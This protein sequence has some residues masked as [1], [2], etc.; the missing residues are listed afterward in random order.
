MHLLVTQVLRILFRHVFVSYGA[1]I[2]RLVE[3]RE[4]IA[5]ELDESPTY[6][7]STALMVKIAEKLPTDFESLSQVGFVCVYINLGGNINDCDAMCR[8]GPLCR[9]WFYKW[10]KSPKKRV[11]AMMRSLDAFRRPFVLPSMNI[12]LLLKIFGP[13]TVRCLQFRTTVV[14]F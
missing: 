5:L 14:L 12:M 7:C 10:R 9:P 2:Q 1:A 11:P 13:S 6:I 3:W 4:Q 8:Y